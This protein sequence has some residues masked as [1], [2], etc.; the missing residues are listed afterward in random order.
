MRQ[1]QVKE[2]V[3]HLENRFFSKDSVHVNIHYMTASP[4]LTLWAENPLL[5]LAALC[6]VG[7]RAVSLVSAH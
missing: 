3:F 4:L 2:K 1:G 6:I 7:N 5:W